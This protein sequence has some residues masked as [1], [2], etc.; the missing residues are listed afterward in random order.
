[1][2]S[3]N[4]TANNARKHRQPYWRCPIMGFSHIYYI[5]PMFN[6]K[7]FVKVSN[8]FWN[9]I[10][11]LSQLGVELGDGWGVNTPIASRTK[12]EFNGLGNSGCEPF[13]LVLKF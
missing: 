9:M 1:M 12:I 11:P 7:A 8:D 5:A 10:T 6:K 2:I 3:Q 4:E 13:S